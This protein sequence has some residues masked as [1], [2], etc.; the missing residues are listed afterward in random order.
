MEVEP[1]SSVAGLS[2]AAVAAEAAHAAHLS[3]AAVHLAAS[4]AKLT[5]TPQERAAAGDPIAQAHVAQEQALTTPISAQ[6]LQP[7]EAAQLLPAHPAGGH[8]PG[9]GELIDVY[10]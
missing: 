5:E 6:G 9:K 10:D 7:T 2:P 3:P 4:K 8:E 1:I